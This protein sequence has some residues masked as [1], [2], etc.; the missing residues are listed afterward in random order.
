MMYLVGLVV[1]QALF[2]Y[3]RTIGFVKWPWYVVAV[4]L[5]LPAA[6]ILLLI[7]LGVAAQYMGSGRGAAEEDAEHEGEG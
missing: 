3:W 4:P 2:I 1:V 6:F 7:V 5:G